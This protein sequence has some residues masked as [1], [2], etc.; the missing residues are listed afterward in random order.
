M[1]RN[2]GESRKSV[3]ISEIGPACDRSVTKGKG[4]DGEARIILWASEAKHGLN[5]EQ[6]QSDVTAAIAKHSGS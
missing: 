6:L 3:L 2:G 5:Q 1:L 4:R